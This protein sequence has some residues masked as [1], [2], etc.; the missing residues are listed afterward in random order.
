MVMLAVLVACSSAPNRMSQVN[1]QHAVVGGGPTAM[2]RAAAR[3]DLETIHNLIDAG[4]PINAATSEGSALSRAIDN[5][6]MNVAM[7][8]LSIGAK[9]DTGIPEG[10]ASPLMKMARD[11]ETHMVRL[12]LA[13]GA[14]VD[15]ADRNGDTALAQAAR[16]GNLTTVKALLAAGADVNVSPSGHSLLMHIVSNNDL[17][18]AQVLIAAGADINFR[19]DDGKSALSLAREKGYGNMEMLLVQSG[20][21]L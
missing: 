16:Q 1:R 18:L 6:Q 14:D 20:A 5:R 11:G 2:M 7:Y 8:L 13:A 21:R 17:L 4:H 3:G 19:S 10:E 9:P 15:Y 12:L